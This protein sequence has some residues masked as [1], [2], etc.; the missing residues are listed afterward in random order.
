MKLITLLILTVAQTAFTQHPRDLVSSDALAVFSIKDGATINK[1]IKSIKQKSGLDNPDKGVSEILSQF[2]KNHTAV[3]VSEEILFVIEP[4]KFGIGLKPT[5]MFGSMPHLVLICKPKE[6]SELEIVPYSGVNSSTMHEGWFIASGSNNWTPPALDG[7]SPILS[8]LPAGQSGAFIKFDKLW[9]QLGPMV[10]MTGGV[11]IGQRN[12]PG[13]KGVIE[14]E[15]R[16]QT[17]AMSRAFRQVMKYCSKIESITASASIVGSDL[18]TEV[19]LALKNAEEGTIDN[20][21]LSEMASRLVAGNVLQYAMSEDFT[22]FLLQFQIESLISTKSGGSYLIPVLRGMRE[23]VDIQGDN[24]VAYGLDNSSGFT[25]TALAET[26]DTEAY[27]ARVPAMINKLSE[28][29]KEDRG[30]QFT[31]MDE[32]PTMWKVNLVGGDLVVAMMRVVFPKD[33]FLVFSDIGSMVSLSFGPESLHQFAD[34][35]NQTRLTRTIDAH[36]DIS[37]DF[38]M[39]VDARKWAFG[40]MSLTTPSEN[41]PTSK[42]HSSPSAQTNIVI[43]ADT[44]GFVLD[45]KMDL[46]GFAKLVGDLEKSH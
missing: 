45:L 1:T 5:G 22:K 14:P 32:S 6:G 19:A 31:P 10:Q 13:P 15:T 41:L 28:Q 38:A 40:V 18:E 16:K 11:L 8:K 26:P 29:F 3:D 39:S 27:L 44:S 25:I 21:S 17:A 33:T 2:I 46:L 7:L 42:I 30:M 23:L 43:G 20:S 35:N 34:G 24:V 37:I 4:E 9:S 36:G 12:K